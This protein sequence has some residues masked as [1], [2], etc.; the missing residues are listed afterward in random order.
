MKG[1]EK[2]YGIKNKGDKYKTV[3]EEVRNIGT[4]EIISC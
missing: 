1:V 2:E 3:K 4:K